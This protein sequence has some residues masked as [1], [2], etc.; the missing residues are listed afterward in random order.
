MLMI[1]LNVSLISS[2]NA[3]RK[4]LI[5]QINQNNSEQRCFG[6]L[7]CVLGCC[8]L[9]S[10]SAVTTAVC[11]PMAGKLCLVCSIPIS[12]C[13]SVPHMPNPPSRVIV[14]GSED[15]PTLQRKFQQAKEELHKSF[16]YGCAYGCCV[17]VACMKGKI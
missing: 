6:V 5:A 13:F 9:P 16:A 17:G 1:C 8:F 14:N 10:V 15:I 11:P 4:K 3:E 2:D 12:L 7:G